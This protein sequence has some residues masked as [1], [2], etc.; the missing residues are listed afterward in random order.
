VDANDFC[1]A[2][3]GGVPGLD[4]SAL[5]VV[6]DAD[7][8]DQQAGELSA[9]GAKFQSSFSSTATGW[10]ALAGPYQTPEQPQLLATF[11]PVNTWAQD[12][13]DGTA[14]VAS[15]LT[16]FAVDCRDAKTR[17]NALTDAA[18]QLSSRIELRGDGKPLFEREFVN[19]VERSWTWQSNPTM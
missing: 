13:Q 2:P 9:A 10:N 11:G 16:V 17:S 12:V 4:L 5:P 7:A 18:A 1:A 14:A 19:A 8:L 15:A 3:V 6:P